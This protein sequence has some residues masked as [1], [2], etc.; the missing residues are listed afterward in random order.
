MKKIIFTLTSGLLLLSACRSGKIKDPEYRDI[1][2]VKLLKPGILESTAAVDIVYY[3]PNNFSVQLKDAHGDLYIDNSY[4][5]HFVVE[6]NV[7]VDRKSEFVILAI[8]KLDMIGIVKNQ[9]DIWKKKEAL[10]KVDGTARVKKAGVAM[11][12]PISYEG[13][14]NI[15]RF[16]T[17]VSK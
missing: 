4:V 12:V 9:Q 14:Q 2:D 7:Q 17:L 8:F 6:D 15:E 3:N 11:N 5:G 10:I 1:R 16:R 13:V